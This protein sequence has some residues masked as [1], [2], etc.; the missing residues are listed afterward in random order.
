MT[1]NVFPEP[2]KKLAE[3]T[4]SRLFVQVRD[5]L[6]EASEDLGRHKVAEGVGWEISNGAHR[7]VDILQHAVG[8]GV[9]NYPQVSLHAVIPNVR[10]VFDQYAAFQKSVFDLEAQH[11]VEVVGNLVALNADQCGSHHINRPVESIRVNTVEGFREA[12]AQLRKVMG[13]K[14]AAATDQDLPET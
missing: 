12:F 2:A 8:I 1:V 9:G 3:T 7:P 13:P 5:I 14:G 11:D 10:Q 4:G 6:A